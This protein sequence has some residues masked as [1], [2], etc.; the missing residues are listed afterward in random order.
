MRPYLPW[1]LLLLALPLAAQATPTA[2]PLDPLSADEMRLAVEILRASGQ[3]PDPAGF[4]VLALQEP[5]KEEV[6]RFRPGQPFR[7]EAL[8]VVLDRKASR[9]YEAVVDLRARRLLRWRHVPEVQPLLLFEEYALAQ[10]LVR[11]DSRWRAA[12]RRRGIADRD[13]GAVALEPWAIGHAGPG[14]GPARRLVRVM[15]FFLGSSSN[16]YARPLE[17]VVATVDL[18]RREVLAVTDTGVPRSASGRPLPV[19]PEPGDY[20]SRKVGPLRPPLRPLR[21]THPEGPNFTLNGHEVR[22]QK[23]RFRLSVHPREGLVLHTVGYEDGGTVRPILYRASLSEMVVPYA[24]PDPAWRWRAAFD[25]GEYGLGVL[26]CSLQPGIDVPDGATFLDAVLP[27]ED[28]SPRTLPRAIALWERDGGLLWR[29]WDYVSDVTHGRRARQLAVSFMAAVGNYDYML[30]WVFSQDGALAL[31]ADLSGIML[32]KGVGQLRADEDHAPFGHLVAPGVSAIH[33][34]HFLHFRLDLDID[35]FRNNALLEMNS[36]PL[37]PQE[38]NPLGNAFRMELTPLRTEA[39]AQ[40]DLNLATSR[41][42]LIVNQV[43]RNALGHPTGFL[44]VPGE[45]AVPLAAPDSAIRRRAGFINHHLWATRYAPGEL[46][47]AGDYPNQRSEPG[48]LPV[49]VANN[50]TLQ[51]QDIV[52]WYTLGVTHIPRPEEWPIMSSHRTGFLLLPAGF[53]HHNPSLDV[54]PS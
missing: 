17:G 24:D 43:R 14:E 10:D 27:R 54:P 51:G 7:R 18:G 23:W 53:F 41:K 20:D 30:T 33:H 16:R 28:G 25:V 42:W 12:M 32:A 6:Y 52:L 50:D 37:P 26:G 36:H 13:L 46:Y 40:R 29:H 31:E 38:H 4:P 11:A 8:A 44:L 48:G 22:W 3:L 9:T 15:S 1:P 34:Q 39:Q 21:I 49:Y 45:N 47:A 5:P 2:H 19:P 35:G